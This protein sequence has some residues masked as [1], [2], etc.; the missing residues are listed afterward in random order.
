MT[1]EGKVAVVTGGGSGI[2]EA[3][4]VRLA[5]DGAKVAVL[6]VNEDAAKRTAEGIGG[7]AV[8][9]DVSDSASVDSALEEAE[10]ALGPV[11]VWVNNAGIAAV[12][13]ARRLGSAG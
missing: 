3:I 1:L 5:A 7:V 11:D 12:Q 10:A 6:D 13:Q 9:A 2:G 4:C 8:R